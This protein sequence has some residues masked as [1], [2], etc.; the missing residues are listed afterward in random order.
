MYQRPKKNSVTKC[1]T[2]NTLH[3]VRWSFWTRL[4]LQLAKTNVKYE[5]GAK[6]RANNCI[7][8]NASYDP[9]RVKRYLRAPQLSVN[10]KCG[11]HNNNQVNAYSTHNKQSGPCGTPEFWWLHT[12]TLVLQLF[13][14]VFFL[15]SF[16]NK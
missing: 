11:E 9:I 7:R 2:L 12:R 15:F 1:S 8:L 6:Y 3:V 16:Q 4:S 5:H 10:N 13:L 14:G